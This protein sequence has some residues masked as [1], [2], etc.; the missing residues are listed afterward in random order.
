MEKT[1]LQKLLSSRTVW[2]L[3]FMFVFNGFQSIAG[4]LPSGVND[5][6]NLLLTVLA[7][8]FKLN[9]TQTYKLPTDGSAVEVPVGA[10]VP[11]K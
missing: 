9:P 2:T 5:I 11:A 7:G 6:V 1:T 3:V 10:R 4:S 8:Y